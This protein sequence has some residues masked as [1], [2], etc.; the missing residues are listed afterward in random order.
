[1]VKLADWRGSVAEV[2]INN[3]PAGTIAW[4]P[5]ELDITD[6]ITE[7]DND[8]SVV[9]YGT[10]KNLLGPHHIGA[11]RGTAWP[12]SFASANNN[13]PAGEEYD[14]IDYGLFQD[15][16]LI[17]SDGPPQKVYWRI[18]KVVRPEFNSVDSIS[19]TPITVSLSTKTDGAEIRYT[20]DGS[21]P[22]R[23]SH[24][25]TK[26]LLLKMSSL[27]TAQSFKNDFTASPIVQRK[28]YIIK[29]R[30]DEHGNYTYENGMEYYYYEGMWSKIP[31]FELLTELRKGQIYGFNLDG[32][33]RRFANFALEFVG[34][35]KIEQGG[36]YTF[37]ISSNDGSILYI[38]DIPVVDNDGTHGDIE[39]TGQIELTPGLHPLELHYFDGGG[40]QSLKVQYKGP[41][42]ERQIIPVDKLMHRE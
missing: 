22:N 17:E 32:L 37:Y 40:S 16:I 27:V 14:F 6:K 30:I 35:I 8:I 9:V 19:N 12:A 13:I 1:V 23:K 29:K 5:Y 24:L 25:Y 34:Y 4:P 2:K 28:F 20:L 15:F 26:P 36:K 11:V 42:I 39:R 21:T 3:K 7:G 38:N 33:E 10:L 31:D 18:K 41:G